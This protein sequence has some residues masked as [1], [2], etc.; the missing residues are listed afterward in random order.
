[1]TKEL[2]ATLT[3][4]ITANLERRTISGQLVPWDTIGH[5]SAGP[6]RFAAGSVTLPDDLS[7]VKLLRDHNTSSPIGYLIDAHSTDGGLF[8]TFKIPETSAGDEA[9]LEASAKL[10]DGLSVG[11]TL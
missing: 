2:L 10:R 11:V 9:L 7:R 1:M 4:G 6:T 5:T 3:T 8:G